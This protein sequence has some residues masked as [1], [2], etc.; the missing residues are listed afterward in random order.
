VTDSTDSP[1]RTDDYDL[2]TPPRMIRVRQELDSLHI[3]LPR[4]HGS[5]RALRRQTMLVM[6]V[7]MF[8]TT[9]AGIVGSLLMPPLEHLDPRLNILA[10]PVMLMVSILPYLGVFLTLRRATATG[11]VVLS[12]RMLKMEGRGELELP[13]EEVR[14][15][16]VITDGDRGRLRFLTTRGDVELFDGLFL[17]ELRWLHRTIHD[18]TARLRLQMQ[19]EGHDTDVVARP[20]EAITRLLRE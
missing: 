12:Q 7:L 3:D 16:E 1:D 4:R 19:A 5:G 18:H 13:L 2:L 10:V 9:C 15:I 6:G 14:D 20:P 8:T 11:E 17:H